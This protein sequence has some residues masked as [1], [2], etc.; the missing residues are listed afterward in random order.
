MVIYNLINNVWSIK[1]HIWFGISNILN[2]IWTI[3][4][5]I[6]SLKSVVLASFIIIAFTL[7]IFKTWVEMGNIP[8]RKITILT[9]IMRNIWAFYLGWCIAASN[10]SFGMN[11]VYWWG[12]THETQ[13]IIFWIVAPLCAIGGFAYNY[14]K[15]GKYGALSCFCLWFSVAWAF[16]GA[17]ITTNKC[18]SGKC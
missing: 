11:I 8:F 2:I 12:Y 14:L 16:L 9:Y 5:D 15:Y 17:A 18:L 4:F 1:T 3:V 13:M 6:G 10:I 7:S